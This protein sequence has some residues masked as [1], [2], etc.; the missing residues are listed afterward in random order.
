MDTP[1]WHADHYFY[2]NMGRGGLRKSDAQPLPPF[3]TLKPQEMAFVSQ[4]H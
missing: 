4:T 2:M 1:F 3:L